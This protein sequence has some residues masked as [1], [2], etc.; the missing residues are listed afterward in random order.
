MLFALTGAVVGAAVGARF[1]VLVLVPITLC[2]LIV[3]GIAYLT[4]SATLIEAILLAASLQ[5]GYLGSAGFCLA[6]RRR[7]RWAAPALR[8][9]AS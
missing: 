8:Q 6:F 4:A 9:R 1:T 3:L 7:S 2:A 5:A